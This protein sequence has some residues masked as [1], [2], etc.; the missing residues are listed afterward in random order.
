MHHGTIVFIEIPVRSLKRA[1]DFYAGLFG[2]P[3]VEDEDNPRRWLFTPYGLGAMG[4]ITTDRPAGGGGA[5]LSI[6]VDDLHLTSERAI[7][8]GGGPGTVL[9]T[10]V[11]RKV[12]IVDPDGNHLWAHQSSI[13]RKRHHKVQGRQPD[14]AQ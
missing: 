6:A 12:E 3:F 1:A 5:R 9:E 2:W 4:A 14:E 8:L 10:A 7:A 13:K 11:G